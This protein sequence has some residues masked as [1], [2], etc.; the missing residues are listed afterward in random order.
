MHELGIVFE[1]IK[2]VHALTKE[3]EIEPEDLAI[4]VLEIGEASTIVPRY[5]LE[6]WPA[7]I[8]GS[9]F[10]HVEL[11]L[12]SIVATVRCKNCN[13]IYEYLH[14]DKHCPHCNNEGCVMVTGK[15]FNLKELLLYE[16]EDE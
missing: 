8:D 11:Q 16:E 12:D 10:E 6:C 4:V 5:L 14:H 3:Y 2:R 1:V 7:A 15:E 9:E 13:T